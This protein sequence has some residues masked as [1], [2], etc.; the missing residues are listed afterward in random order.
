MLRIA[1]YNC[2]GLPKSSSDLHLRAE[3]IDILNNNDVVCLQETWYSKQNLEAI[4]AIHADFHGFGCSKIDYADGLISGRP[5]GGVAILWRKTLGFTVKQLSLQLDWCLAAE[6]TLSN[7]TKLVILSVYLPYQCDDN[8]DEYV[9]KLGALGAVM[10]ELDTTCYTV[11]GDW[12]ANLKQSDSPFAKLLTEFCQE[13]QLIISSTKML[14]SNSYTYVSE[15]W[16]TTSWLDHVISSKDFDECIMDININYDVTDEDHIPVALKVNV[17]SLPAVISAVNS[18]ASNKICWQNLSSQQLQ[19]YCDMTHIELQKI[20]MPHEALA[21]TNLNCEDIRH[22]HAIEELYDNIVHT[23]VSC[24]NT[25]FTCHGSNSHS[26]P[27]WSD[28]VADI[29]AESREARNLWLRA[30]SPRSGPLLDN[31]LRIK[32]QFKRS[33]RFIKKN[34]DALRRDSLAKKL[35]DLNQDQ[36]WKEIKL[37]NNSHTPLPVTVEGV[38]GSDEIANMWRS[39]FQ[40]I[41]NILPRDNSEEFA[42]TEDLLDDVVVSPVEIE[43]I[44][45]DLPSRKSCGSDSLSVEH[46][47]YSS[48]VLNLLLSQCISS[49]FVHSFLPKNLMS[50]VLVPI[51]KDKG[52]SINCKNNYRPIALANVVSKVIEKIILNRIEENLYTHA[53]QFG[54]KKNHGTDQCIYLLKEVI[55][56]YRVLNGSMFVCF[57][58]ASKAFDR[59]SH[60]KLFE[61]LSK[62]GVPTYIMKLLMYWYCNQTFCVR[63]GSSVSA[64]FTVTNGVRQG[65]ILSPVLFNVYFDDLSSKLNHIKCGCILNNVIMNHLMYADDLVVFAPSL[66]GLQLLLDNCAIFAEN[67]DVMFN[68]LKSACM[69]FRPKNSNYKIASSV[70]LNGESLKV[71]SNTKYLG[72]RISNDLSDDLD[73]SRQYRQLYVQG[74][75]LLRKFHMCSIEVKLRL[76]QTYCSP[77]YTPHLWWNF[78]KYSWRKLNTAYHNVLK[79]L[80]GLSKYESSSLVCT[81]TNIRSCAALVRNYV[82]KF[83]GRLEKSSNGIIQDLLN[84]SIVYASRI[85]SHWLKLLYSGAI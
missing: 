76:F 35:C 5:Y 4:N 3:I 24:G 38:S 78:C 75:V 74:N 70:Y 71:V 31:H 41:F 53:N 54:F 9:D 25:V 40:T 50:V 43:K 63:W 65:G 22:R 48:K 47:Q 85:R 7:G 82:Y 68:P 45:K 36:F 84:T 59:I 19:K 56:Y 23:L 18:I 10:D 33:L 2:R 6:L 26:R 17:D 67:N 77:M 34:E 57:L 51:I 69:I 13:R 58:D 14:P 1:S 30:G 8:Y 73:M 29:Y 66:I 60:D 61:K 52:A 55:D 81:V 21:C 42:T 79:L 37:I 12:N 11:V 49:L 32:A 72:H 28:Y 20:E 64:P 39:H 16:G 62:R 44:I 80:I 46:M 27:G 15:A 83:M